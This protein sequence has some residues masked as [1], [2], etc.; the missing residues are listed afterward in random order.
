MD[1]K[2]QAVYRFSGSKNA[3]ADQDTAMIG[4]T[5]EEIET[6]KSLSKVAFENRFCQVRRRPLL[7]IFLVDPKAGGDEYQIKGPAFSIAI[8]FPTTDKLVQEKTY[9]I[10]KVLRDQIIRES[11]D[12]ADEDEDLIGEAA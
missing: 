8:C 9:Q 10:N 6:A 4:L 3:V 1:E 11:E 12:N 2:N 5:Q 7:V